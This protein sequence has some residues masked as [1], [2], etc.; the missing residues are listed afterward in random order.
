MLC[1]LAMYFLYYSLQYNNAAT[2]FILMPLCI[3]CEGRSDGYKAMSGVM[4]VFAIGMNNGWF[5][6]V[7]LILAAIGSYQFDYVSS[8]KIVA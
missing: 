1:L 5:L 6:F 3:A 2:M 8:K 4:T 7:A